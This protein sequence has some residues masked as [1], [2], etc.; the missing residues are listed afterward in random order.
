[1]DWEELF[2][3]SALQLGA[4]LKK[5]RAAIEHRTL[6]G[7]LNERAFAAWLRTWLP[8][9]LEVGAGEVIDSTGGRSRQADVVVYDSRTMPRF[10]SRGNDI[11]VFP[12]EPVF[13]IIEIKTYLNKEELDKAFEN[14]TR[15][16]SL[17]KVGYHSHETPKK[18][19]LYGIETDRWL[20][21]FFIFAYESDQLETLLSHALRLN[22]S[23]P[24]SKQ[25]D[26]VC[27]L[28][29]GLLVHAGPGGWEPIPMPH[30]HMVAKPSSKPFTGG[31]NRPRVLQVLA[32]SRTRPPR[33]PGRGRGQASRLSPLRPC[34]RGCRELTISGR[35]SRTPL[36]HRMGTRLTRGLT[37]RWLGLRRLSPAACADYVSVSEHS[38]LSSS[39]REQKVGPAF[40]LGASDPTRA[41]VKRPCPKPASDPRAR[42]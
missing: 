29:K 8:G 25:I 21:Q 28:D 10:L 22:A 41:R 12:I 17:Q 33:R 9:V 6:K 42:G 11:D 3:A 15:V 32:G 2:S 1:M 4:N 34:Y 16:K 19:V 20:L 39:A 13:A 23:Q 27:V 38:P 14:M 31:G 37:R 36:G 18:K 35:H 5:A 30:T 40:R 26:C 24:L 7:S